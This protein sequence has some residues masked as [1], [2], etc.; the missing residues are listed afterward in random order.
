[1]LRLFGTNMRRAL[2]CFL[3]PDWL[4]AAFILV[5]L[6]TLLILATLT[7]LG[8]SPDEPNHAA[9]AASIL[10]GQWLGHRMQL[11]H[12]E[13]N[14]PFV[15]AGVDIDPGYSRAFLNL[16]SL[17]LAAHKP[18]SLEMVVSTFRARW[19]GSAVFSEASNTAGYA[20]IFYFPSALGMGL[21]R[22]VRSGPMET[23]LSGRVFNAIFYMLIGY[24][25]LRSSVHIRPA[26]F[27]LLTLPMSLYLGATINQDGPLIATAALASALLSKGGRSYWAGT[28]ALA[29]VVVAKPPYMPLALVVL[30]ALSGE[31]WSAK[32]HIGGLLLIVLLGSAWAATSWL[33]VNVPFLRLPYHPGPLWPADP[34]IYSHSTDPAAQ[35]RVLTA[36]PMRFISL[37]LDAFSSIWRF[38]LVTAVG[39]LGSLDFNLPNWIYWMWFISLPT[40]MLATTMVSSSQDAESPPTNF[41]TKSIS[42]ALTLVGCVA[43]LYG[44]FLLQYLTWTDVGHQTIDGMQG[45]YLLPILPT[46]FLGLSTVLPSNRNFW[47]VGLLLTAP[48]IC[49]A[50]AGLVVLPTCTVIRYYL[51]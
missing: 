5:A 51:R 42:L 8:E 2:K 20:P 35:M 36:H 15:V 24:V 7:P 12:P 22:L 39:R 9:R 6:P 32:K 29:C 3:K 49:S 23:V 4:S 31:A 41:R 16:P 19:F 38:L 27:A 17:P 40:A 50:V 28:A 30:A 21:A 13:D 37:P 11:T 25:A 1:M 14:T 33:F 47:K 43:S 18:V 26:L 34:N 46:M 45:R 48:A 10:N 44:I